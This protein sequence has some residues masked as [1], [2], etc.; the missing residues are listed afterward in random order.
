MRA[1]RGA[2]QDQQDQRSPAAGP[3]PGCVQLYSTAVKANVE[4]SLPPLCTSLGS[5]GDF[6]VIILSMPLTYTIAIEL[7]I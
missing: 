7:Q 2:A 3:G 4:L 5:P 1:S 6:P